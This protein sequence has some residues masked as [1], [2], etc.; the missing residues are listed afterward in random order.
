MTLYLPIG[1]LAVVEWFSLLSFLASVAALAGA[2]VALHRG[3]QVAAASVPAQLAKGWEELA[4]RVLQ[5]EQVVEAQR[6]T[7]IAARTEVDAVLDSVEDTLERVERKRRSAA[8]SASRANGG[9]EEPTDPRDILRQQALAAGFE[10][11]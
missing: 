1:K 7:L 4:A 9:Q 10:V 6:A 8:A 11:A 2:G 3:Q 5:C